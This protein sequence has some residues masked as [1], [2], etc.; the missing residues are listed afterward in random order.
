MEGVLNNSRRQAVYQVGELG[1]ISAARRA[2]VDLARQLGFDETRTGMLAL[3]ITEAATNIVKHA[4]RGEI[5]LR[6]ILQESAYGVEVLAIDSGAG[7]TNLTA[8]IRDGES[9]AGTYGIGLG[10]IHRLADAFDLHS[11]SGRGTVLWAQLWARADMQ[12]S[13]QWDIGVVC[14]PIA[15]EEACG[16]DWS[17]ISKPNSITIL[18]AD[19]LGHG[20]D[21]ARASH[22]AVEVLLQKADAYPATVI[23]EAHSALAG[24]RGAAIAVVQINASLEQ[25]RFSGIGNVEACIIDGEVSRHMMAHNGIVGS[26]LRKVQEFTVPWMTDS[27]LVMHSDGLGTR[28]NLAGYPGLC[29]CHPA[30]IAATLYRDFVRRRDDVTVLVLRRSRL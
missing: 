17:T 8:S 13:A 20:P 25:L 14:L 21:A 7:I 2:G 9:T 12:L 24:T 22:A 3:I 23:R 28:W 4:G 19:G 26:N 30:V 11:V 29:A 10:A 27:T 1:E 6:T 18:V 15:S 5:I 16:D